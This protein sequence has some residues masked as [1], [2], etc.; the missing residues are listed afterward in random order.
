MRRNFR[1]YKRIFGN[2][3]PEILS[4]FKIRLEDWRLT[5]VMPILIAIIFIYTLIAILNV[6]LDLFDEYTILERIKSIFITPIVEEIVFRGVFLGVF[7]VSV[8][9]I[10]SNL[11]DIKMKSN[12]Y[13]FFIFSGLFI[14]AVW[15]TFQHYNPNASSFY[16][17]LF[18]GLIYGLL[19]ILFRRNL[20]PAIMAHMTNNA[21]IHYLMIYFN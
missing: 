12:A 16:I 4:N 8:P 21:A 1:K 19:Y 13:Y 15:F 14:Q 7:F 17:R 18:D 6:K 11:F 20:L 3:I 9:R 2:S 10:M 5:V